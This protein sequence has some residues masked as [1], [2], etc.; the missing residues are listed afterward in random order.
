MICAFKKRKSFFKV[1]RRIQPLLNDT[2]D[3]YFQIVEHHRNLVDTAIR[4]HPVNVAGIWLAQ[5]PA[6]KMVVFRPFGRN[7]AKTAG[8]R[9]AGS[10]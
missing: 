9:L 2:V 6:T 5:I 7:L 10:G 3:F 4:Q 1:T 8:S